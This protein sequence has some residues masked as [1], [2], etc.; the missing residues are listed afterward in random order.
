MEA[1]KRKSSRLLVDIVD[2][3]ITWRISSKFLATTLVSFS[4]G[5][6]QK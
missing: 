4:G 6:D 3:A 1:K 5:S 2:R